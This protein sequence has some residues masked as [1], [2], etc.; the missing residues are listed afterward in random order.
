M[1]LAEP[2]KPYGGQFLEFYHSSISL[3]TY[4]TCKLTRKSTE[5]CQFFCRQNPPDPNGRT[6]Q[7]LLPAK[8]QRDK[9]IY[10]C[11][12]SF[13]KKETS[14]AAFRRCPRPSGPGKRPHLSGTLGRGLC[15][16]ICGRAFS[17][18]THLGIG[19]MAP[20]LFLSFLF[21]F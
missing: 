5:F 1:K 6:N 18:T 11:G 3:S 16:G 15:T 14:Q 2:Y 19:Y 12:F 17:G 20:F 4:E 8:G 21:V 9:L 10:F 7:R 13:I